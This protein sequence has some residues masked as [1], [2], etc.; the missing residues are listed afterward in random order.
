VIF[1]IAAV[2]KS[3]HFFNGSSNQ[4]FNYFFVGLQ[5][6]CRGLI[7]GSEKYDASKGFKFSTYAHWWIKQ[8]VRK[9]LSVQSRTI[10]LPVSIIFIFDYFFLTMHGNIF[11]TC[12][13]K[14]LIGG[15]LWTGI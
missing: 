4:P 9:S 2:S 11:I 6:G 13:W 10:R 12:L 1:N 3:P 5:E 15:P 8:A 7:R 14:T